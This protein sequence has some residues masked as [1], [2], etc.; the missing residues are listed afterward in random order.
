M[1]VRGTYRELLG[2]ARFIFGRSSGRFL[3]ENAR[4]S[5]VTENTEEQP[6]RGEGEGI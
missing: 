2:W 6:G 5:E 3:T 1:A 4:R